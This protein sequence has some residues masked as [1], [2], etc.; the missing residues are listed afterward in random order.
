M[1]LRRAAPRQWKPE[2]VTFTLPAPA[3]PDVVFALMATGRLELLE[4]AWREASAQLSLDPALAQRAA[5][6]QALRGP[7][8]LAQN[9]DERRGLLIQ[10][11]K[12]LT[13]LLGAQQGALYWG[14]L[15]QVVERSL[16]R[17]GPGAFPW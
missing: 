1:L 9:F 16:L 5:E 4:E 15:E 13:D 2:E 11:R 14:L 8:Q 7:W 10:L 12:N 17:P 6:L 3:R